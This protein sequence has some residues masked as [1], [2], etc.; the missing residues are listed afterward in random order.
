[1]PSSTNHGQHT[2]GVPSLENISGMSP[3]PDTIRC[4]GAKSLRSMWQK[5]AK[6]PRGT[7]GGAS[8]LRFARR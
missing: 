4:P 2:S 5:L 3:V 6:D 7:N 8:H 1:M